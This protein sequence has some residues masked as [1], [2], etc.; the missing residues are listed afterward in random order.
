MTV[1]SLLNDI[2]S[3]RNRLSRIQ[4]GQVRFVDMDSRAALHVCSM[5]D[6]IGSALQASII[7]SK[8]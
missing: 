6:E 8:D 2:G 5:L 3:L 1:D 4:K 7:P